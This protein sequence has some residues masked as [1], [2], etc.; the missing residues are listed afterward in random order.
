MSESLTL[1]AMS[2]KH[3][4]ETG[5]YIIA[6]SIRGTCSLCKCEVWLAPTSF[7]LLAEKPNTK[8]FCEACA[9]GVMETEKVEEVGTVGD[10][11]PRL[12]GRTRRELESG[13]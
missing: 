3:A 8:I 4:E 6:K 7:E 9:L 1:V 10:F 5:A 12:K 11:I 13:P 2:V